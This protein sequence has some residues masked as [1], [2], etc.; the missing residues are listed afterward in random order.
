ML[1]G[2]N[3][4]GIKPGFGGGEER[5]L[6]A[7]TAKMREVQP[8]NGY[9]IF[10][11]PENND[12]FPNWNRQ[13]VNG[14]FSLFS[15]DANI[16]RA[17]RQ[18]G[19]DALFSPLA[20][21]PAKPPVPMVLFSLGLQAFEPEHRHGINMRQAKKICAAAAAIVAP[22][23][24]VQRKYLQLLDTALNKVIVA[25]LGIDPGF[26]KPGQ[27]PIEKPY[28]L[29]VGDTHECKNIPRLRE[30]FT[31]LNGEFPH[32]LVV[33]GRPFEAEP[34][35]WGPRAMRVE[36]C[37]AS[38]LAALY[39]NCDV[40]V[41]P[42]L[43]EGSGITVLEA[44]RA[45]APVATSRTGGIAEVAGDTPFYFNPESVHSMVAT[46]RW[47]LEET[48]EQ[49]KKRSKYGRQMAAEFTWEKCAWKTLSAFKRI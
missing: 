11:D 33:V 15:G 47:A 43:Y 18:A 48:P 5:F 42:S 4:L 2:V 41:Q 25:P 46:I 37:P 28:I 31:V 23:Q 40:Y 44:M 9:V 10:T 30:V 32:S 45:G 35:D 26:E 22:S 13:C 27:C 3:A 24:F 8:D 39:H 36:S 1:I 38:H 6:R 16:E 34:D 49:R 7:V 12:S 29:V 17:V 20:A 19:V 21:A 14:H